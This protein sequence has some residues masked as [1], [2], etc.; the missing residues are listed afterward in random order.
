MPELFLDKNHL[1]AKGAAV[2]GG[3][4]A[5]VLEPWVREQSAR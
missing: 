5:E 2:V 4:L 1:T 3:Q